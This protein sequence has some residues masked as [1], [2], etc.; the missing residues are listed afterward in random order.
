VGG[1]A[2]CWCASLRNPQSLNLYTYVGND[3]V[4]GV[5]ADGHF[6]VG[7]GDGFSDSFS[8]LSPS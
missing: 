5:D 4:D 1:G 3:P 7:N 8:D 2:L 6:V